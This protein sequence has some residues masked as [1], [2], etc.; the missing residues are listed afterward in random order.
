MSSAFQMPTN[1]SK[2]YDDPRIPDTLFNLRIYQSSRVISN[3]AQTYNNKKIVQDTQTK[4]VSHWTKNL[5][6][7]VVWIMCPLII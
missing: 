1:P 5:D 7:L 4:L 2:G 6:L 3:N